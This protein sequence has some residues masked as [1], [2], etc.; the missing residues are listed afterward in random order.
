M[1][2]KTQKRKGHFFV[3]DG[4]DGSGKTTQTELL[5][6]A[7]RKQKKQ[8]LIVDFPQYDSSFFGAMVGVYLKG[9]FG[10]VFKIS[11]YLSSLLYALDRWSARVKIQKALNK[12]K[13][14]LANRYT[15]SN[16]IHQG[17]K[18]K[19]KRDRD[20][21]FQ[22]LD[23]AEF[24]ALD[25]PRPTR[26]LFLDVPTKISWN[27]IEHRNRITHPQGSKRDKHEA[28]R[29][30]LLKAYHTAK[31]YAQN[32]PGWSIVSCVKGSVLSSP[33]EV[34]SRV[35]RIIQRYL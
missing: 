15:S 35:L 34:H 25:I 16:I 6:R 10:D 24:T 22:W 4:P 29:S 2:K 21:F 18:F 14:V 28:S 20:D 33:L 31:T 7:L 9:G 13:I 8:V 5:A 26:V 32:N 19:T 27:L 1:S 23:I 17:A 11:P 3:L 30:H 12:G